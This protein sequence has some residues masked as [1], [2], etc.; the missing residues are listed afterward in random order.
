MHF[1]KQDMAGTHYS[2]DK[3]QPVFAVKQGEQVK[4]LAN[5]GVYEWDCM[6]VDFA[7]GYSL[8]ASVNHEWICGAEINP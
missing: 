2:W 5:T 4:V 3:K 1:Q 7:G 6:N 8:T